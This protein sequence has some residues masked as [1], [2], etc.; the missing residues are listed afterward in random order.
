MVGSNGCDCDSK[1]K[2]KPCVS[3]SVDDGKQML[4]LALNKETSNFFIRFSA[5]AL[6]VFGGDGELPN[7][8]QSRLTC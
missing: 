2:L 3:V 1:A 5:S 4:R 7:P 6:S 8:L